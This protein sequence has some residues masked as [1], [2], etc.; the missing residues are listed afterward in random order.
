MHYFPITRN[1]SSFCISN[2]RKH[3]GVLLM[4]YKSLAFVYDLTEQRN[5][6]KRLKDN[7]VSPI[8][9]QKVLT[10]HQKTLAMELEKNEWIVK[11]K[12]TIQKVKSFRELQQHLKEREWLS[13]SKKISY[14]SELIRELQEIVDDSK[15]LVEFKQMVQ[16][17]K[18]FHEPQHFSKKTK[19]LIELQQTVQQA[20]QYN[21]L[22]DSS[23]ISAMKE[24]WG[25]Y[26]TIV[27]DDEQKKTMAHAIF[28]NIIKNG[29]NMLQD[30][31][32]SKKELLE[33]LTGDEYMQNAIMVNK[34]H[35]LDE[36]ESTN[37]SFSEPSDGLSDDESSSEY[38]LSSGSDL[39]DPIKTSALD[40]YILAKDSIK[41]KSSE[42]KLKWYTYH[43]YKEVKSKS[44]LVVRLCQDPIW[45]HKNLTILAEYD[46]YYA[47][48]ILTHFQLASKLFMDKQMPG[49][50]DVLARTTVIW[51]NHAKKLLPPQDPESGITHSDK[52]ILASNIISAAGSSKDFIKILRQEAKRYITNK[53]TS[54]S[55]NILIETAQMDYFFNRAF[56]NNPNIHRAMGELG[57]IKMLSEARTKQQQQGEQINNIT[58]FFSRAIDRLSQQTWI[59]AF[60]RPQH[61]NLL[62]RRNIQTAR[63][64]KK[65]IKNIFNPSWLTRLARKIGLSK[66][67]DIN[68]TER[69]KAI[70][71]SPLLLNNKD[72]RVFLD[73]LTHINGIPVKQSEH[74]IKFIL[75]DLALLNNKEMRSFLVEKM[76]TNPRRFNF[77]I[78]SQNTELMLQ[79][80]NKINQ[81]TSESLRELYLNIDDQL[82]NQIFHSHDEIFNRLFKGLADE[83]MHSECQAI[84][85]KLTRTPGAERYLKNLNYA[86]RAI[87]IDY[88]VTS[89]ISS[90]PQY[91][92]DD[93][94]FRKEYEYKL[95]KIKTEM[96]INPTYFQEVV[97]S[98]IKNSG[99]TIY[100][101]HMKDGE[102]ILNEQ[103][104]WVQWQSSFNE[105]RRA[106]KGYEAE[107]KAFISE[108][109]VN[110]QLDEEAQSNLAQDV[111]KLL[112]ALARIDCEILN[113]VEQQETL[114]ES[115]QT[116]LDAI[117]N[118][119]KALPT[120]I[121]TELHRFA[122]SEGISSE[123]S[124]SIRKLMLN[125]AFRNARIYGADDKVST[126]SIIKSTTD[127]D[128]MTTEEDKSQFEQTSPQYNIVN[129]PLQDQ[130]FDNKYAAK[131][132]SMNFKRRVSEYRND[133]EHSINDSGKNR[134]NNPNGS[135]LNNK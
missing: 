30:S 114:E 51:S 61:T 3:Y 76:L 91:L 100:R 101:L 67:P 55:F 8:V 15:N 86:V 80:L 29:P 22:A 108:I 110:Y 62:M 33:F 28:D 93:P 72:V 23:N 53:T 132:V 83:S 25:I 89:K 14:V 11:L 94:E 71:Y 19:Q 115:Q 65:L 34:K 32:D 10:T 128:T 56:L 20:L 104:V 68:D 13:N 97:G 102:Q 57:M 131:K 88:L 78:A 60:M 109:A 63:E 46:L 58:N 117:V 103:G 40:A 90:F 39:R 111:F 36:P 135:S 17:E 125:E 38:F 129:K 92:Q 130:I 12:E 6:L 123:A 96:K 116:Y 66:A 70:L 52:R 1:F 64:F 49:D 54:S 73:T 98:M 122:Q 126:Y 99:E 127:A 41:W 35:S 43:F 27:K 69:L 119:M 85:D 74:L 7:L 106:I 4:Q 31:N 82:R 21:L 77:N 5:A 50:K 107:T 42:K 2:Y 44:D 133:Q 87:I 95:E 18:W 45:N 79:L 47:N 37:T 121:R 9:L 24:N 48:I 84:I 120:E 26:K 134:L 105:G 16:K 75:D 113:K 118:K 59:P 112:D 124:Y 81:L